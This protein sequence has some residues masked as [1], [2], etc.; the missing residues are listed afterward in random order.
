MFSIVL[1]FAKSYDITKK[2]VKSILVQKKN[3]FTSIYDS[4]M[5]PEQFEI[6]NKEL[7]SL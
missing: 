6:K 4:T 7:R 3:A 2:Y 5:F 1:I